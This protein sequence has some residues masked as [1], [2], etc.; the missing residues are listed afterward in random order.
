MRH[1]FPSLIHAL[2]NLI[3]GFEYNYNCTF[4]FKFG[5]NKEEQK[6]VHAIHFFVSHTFEPSGLKFT[7][8]FVFRSVLGWSATNNS[9]RI[10]YHQVLQIGL[11]YMVAPFCKLPAPSLC[12]RAHLLNLQI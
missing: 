11:A 8:S 1:I 3:K 6:A 9:I 2:A 5:F 7:R 10:F 12:A 4:K